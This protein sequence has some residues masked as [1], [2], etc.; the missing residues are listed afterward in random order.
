DDY[1]E[2][3]VGRATA[4]PSGHI[5]RE[6]TLGFTSRTAR[7]KDNCVFFLLTLS[8]ACMSTVYFPGRLRN[9]LKCQGTARRFSETSSLTSP[10]VGLATVGCPLSSR[11][12]ISS[13]I[14]GCLLA[15]SR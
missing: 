9:T 2:P 12:R 3:A 6:V 7:G 13:C 15:G 5:H 1:G 11:T 10:V 14:S 8:V 4:L